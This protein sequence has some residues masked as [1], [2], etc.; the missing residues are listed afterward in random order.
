[1]TN[2]QKLISPSEFIE[3]LNESMT[4]PIGKNKVYELIQQPGFPSVKIGN[5][6]YILGDKI[7]EWLEK[8]NYKNR[9][10]ADE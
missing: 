9:G 7:N 10:A 4:T 2:I 6:I 1:M 5:R 8:Q 3:L